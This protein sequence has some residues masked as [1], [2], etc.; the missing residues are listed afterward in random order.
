MGSGVS[1]ARAPAVLARRGKPRPSPGPLH[2]GVQAGSLPLCAI[3]GAHSTGSPANF[4]CF[5]RATGKF[6]NLK[7]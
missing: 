5:Y 7:Q 3:Y 6:P 1:R 4:K 2:R